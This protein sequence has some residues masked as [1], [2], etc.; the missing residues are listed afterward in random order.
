[1]GNKI[2]VSIVVP[3]YNTSK[4]L[5]ECLSSLVNQTLKDIEIICVNDASTDNSLEILNSWAQ[6]DN[7]ITVID[8]KVNMRQGAARNIAIKAAKGKYIGLV[9]SDD[10][11]A[12]T[13]YEELIVNSDNGQADIVVGNMYAMHSNTDHIHMQFP[14]DIA[15]VDHIKRIVI[16]NSCQMFTNI[17]KK[18]LFSKYNLWYPTQIFYEDVANG[19]SLF[20]V[21]DNIK[22]CQNDYP[23][24][25]YR[26]DN[27]STVRKMDNPKCW[28]RLITA[29]MFLENTKRLGCYESYKE[30]IDYA[31]FRLSI[32]NSFMFAIFS[33]SKYQYAKV[34]EIIL[35]Y[36]NLAGFNIIQNNKYYI[37]YNHLTKRLAVAMFKFPLIGYLFWFYSYSK[38]K[39]KNFTYG[40]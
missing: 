26:I 22:I 11:I 8:S 1:M 13:M 10:Y 3:V 36:Q 32:I 37:K 21:A 34:K 2:L 30:E 7:R 29:K 12:T 33:F 20:L 40:W 24:Y 19:T 35:D 39:L 14:K 23:F 27:Q 28:D 38:R 31:Y 4:Y 18:E 5:D 15:D 16:V 6:K 17:F 9:D 25:F